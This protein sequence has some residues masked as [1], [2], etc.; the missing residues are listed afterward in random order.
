VAGAEAGAEAAIEGDMAAAAGPG[1][2]GGAMPAYTFPT[3]PPV[4]APTCAA[5]LT[6]CAKPKCG[7]IGGCWE[8]NPEDPTGWTCTCMAMPPPP[9]PGSLGWL[10][11]PENQVQAP[12]AGE[13]A[14]SAMLGMYETGKIALNLDNYLKYSASKIESQAELGK[15][16]VNEIKAAQP[17]KLVTNPDGAVVCQDGGAVPT[18]EKAAE[19]EKKKKGLLGLGVLGLRQVGGASTLAEEGQE[20][21]GEKAEAKVSTRPIAIAEAQ[22]FAKVVASLEKQDSGLPSRERE[23]IKELETAS[24]DYKGSGASRPAASLLMAALT[25]CL[26]A[27]MA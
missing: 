1:G 27:A 25:A 11:K 15:M 24:A 16:I 13:I 14:N 23:E 7:K 9:A 12:P 5:G 22:K 10:A 6:P 19:G 18:E 4:Q 21:E 2:P 3:A 17:C 20:A 26:V 8:A